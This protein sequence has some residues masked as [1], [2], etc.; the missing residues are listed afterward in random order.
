MY[1]YDLLTAVIDK[2]NDLSS[3]H[4][5]NEADALSRLGGFVVCGEIE[6]ANYLVSCDELLIEDEKCDAIIYDCGTL[7]YLYEIEE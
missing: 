1:I 4:F 7:H 6:K 5:D 2:T 3:Y